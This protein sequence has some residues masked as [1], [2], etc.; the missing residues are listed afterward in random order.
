MRSYARGGTI[1]QSEWLGRE[2][3]APALKDDVVYLGIQREL[4]YLCLRV[5][6]VFTSSLC[7]FLN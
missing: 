6:G 3:S 7:G 4:T 5:V 2:D 1:V